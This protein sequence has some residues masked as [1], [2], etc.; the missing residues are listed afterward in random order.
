MLYNQLLE[1]RD[2]GFIPEPMLAVINQDSSTTLYDFCQ[3]TE[4]YHLD[5]ILEMEVRCTN[6]PTIKN[7]SIDKLETYFLSGK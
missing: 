7:A 3:S 4:L 1:A 5:E 2:A 6:R